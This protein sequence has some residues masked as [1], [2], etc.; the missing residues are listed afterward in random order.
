MNSP[1]SKTIVRKT[2]YQQAAEIIQREYVD[3]K[4]PGV[5]LPSEAELEKL[6]G[7]SLITIRAA[8]NELE[9]QQLVNRRPGSGTYVAEKC[10]PKKHTAILLDVDITSENLSPYYIKWLR[11]LQDVFR[12][13]G[14]AHRPYLGTLPLGTRP[15]ENIT[16]QELLDDIKLGRI[17]AILGNF[18]SFKPYWG[19]PFIEQG[20][21]VL[22]LTYTADAWSEACIHSVF[23]YFR[24][25]RR[26][27]VA[28]IG[29]EDPIDGRNFITKQVF[30]LAAEYNILLEESL[31]N[32]DVNGW[33]YGGGWE[34]FR[35][36]WRTKDKPD[37][38]FISD[39]ML[40]D[41]CQKA[42]Q[43]LEISV[44]NDLCVAVHTSDAHPFPDIRF[45]VFAWQ[46][47]IKTR[48]QSYARA[49]KAMLNGKPAP[50]AVIDYQTGMLLPEQETPFTLAPEP[51]VNMLL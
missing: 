49:M 15:D 11:T 8:L 51:P 20:I 45:P 2:L 47:T 22:D 46:G 36:I 17:H 27:R 24:K 18:V 28:M 5:R 3:G 4:P 10:P 38:L 30:K 12:A 25:N 21:S 6:L 7:V 16:C 34:R 48:A 29:W 32:M 31:I 42:I 40:F 39:D 44:P 41:D 43:E 33:E 50:K 13:E 26:K 1:L 35:E 19:K 37:G 9:V 14:I 23:S